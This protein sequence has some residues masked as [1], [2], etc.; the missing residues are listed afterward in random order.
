M[1]ELVRLLQVVSGVLWLVPMVLASRSLWRI[2]GG[3]ADIRDVL[4][5]PTV[6]VA[7]TFIIGAG[8]WLAFP[9]TIAVMREAELVFWIG[10]YALN[11]IS[12]I[13]VSWALLYSEQFR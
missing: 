5:V 1:T 13:G 12:A 7:L 4:R 9:E 8:R 11:I 10:A 6:L 2:I 3:T